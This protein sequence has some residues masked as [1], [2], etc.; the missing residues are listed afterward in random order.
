MADPESG[1]GRSADERSAEPGRGAEPPTGALQESGAGTVYA[2]ERAVSDGENA[3]S[4][5]EHAAGLREEVIGARERAADAK[6]EVEAVGATNLREA[7]EKLV[8][9]AVRAQTLASAAEDTNRRQEEFLA[10][11]AH[12]L[13]NPLAPILNA[14][15]ILQRVATSH[16]QLPWIHDVIKRQAGHM[17]RLL[18]D[19]LDVARVTSGKITLQ[20]RPVA[21]SEFVEQAVETSR[22][23]ID[24]RRQ[25]LTL[26]IPPEPLCVYGDAARLAQV[27]SNLLNNASKYTDE[28]GR[29]T[30]SGHARGDAVLL[31]VADDGSGISEDTLP[32]IFDLFTQADRS[33]ARAQGGLG[34]GLTVVRGLVEMHGGTVTAASGGPNQGSEFV[35]T[36]PLLE[37]TQ[38]N[39][40]AVEIQPPLAG[41]RY[42][43]ALIED[44]V[45]ANDVLRTLLEM[46]GHEVM[47]AFDG[48]TGAALVASS[49][50]QV[51]L[52]DIGL[53]QLD[54]YGVVAQLRA[55]MTPPLPC[56]IAMTGYGQ[57]E[58][59]LRALAAGFD[60]HF[61]KPIDSEKLLET[62]AAHFANPIH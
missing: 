12:E 43:I 33:L 39:A 45:D 22:P 59:R 54:G 56:L 21:V 61:V 26:D 53:P 30:L 5:R 40:R 34:I 42:T 32:R 19:L 47:P 55:E 31:R 2:R 4:H 10:M 14:A 15:A 11:L 49:R 25:Q 23:L 24:S 62:V 29:I 36:L 48:V 18:D 57:A 1:S 52:C 9:A 6:S 28:G 51:V 7:N 58:D 60:Y 44:N 35:V 41:R 17:T 38:S 8:I 16:P 3:L 20:R 13:R 37:P 50:P 27:F 46:S